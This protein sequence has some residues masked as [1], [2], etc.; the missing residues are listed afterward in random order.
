[1]SSK[2]E[3]CLL[4]TMLYSKGKLLFFANNAIMIILILDIWTWSNCTMICQWL[5]AGQWF[6]P[7]TPVSYTN[8]TNCHDITKILSKVALNSITLTLTLITQWHPYFKAM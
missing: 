4:Y 1:M 3:Q 5:A 2:A 8:K 7:G 6:Y